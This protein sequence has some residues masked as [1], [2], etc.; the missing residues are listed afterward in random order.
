MIAETLATAASTEYL[1]S[2]GNNGAFGRFRAEEPI[3]LRRGERVVIR[4]TRGLE[5]GAVLCPVTANHTRFL[6]SDALP[7]LLVRRATLEDEQE[8]R[9]LHGVGQR[10]FD[11]GRRLAAE[12]EL[13]LE[14]LD[15]ELLLDGRRA[16]LQHVSNRQCDC[17]AFLAELE[18]RHGIQVWLENLA[19][20][21]AKDEDHGGCDKPDCGRNS[22]GCTSCSTG[23]CS[24]CG[25]GKVDMTAYFAHLRTQ[26][27][28]KRMPL[29]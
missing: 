18:R 28:Q 19:S 5:L 24:S 23:G 1:V 17:D 15:V 9:R 4:T 22:G 6:D 29:L 16:I 8:S 10:L 14:I 3:T 21:A 12:L 20:P 13:P 7:G 27:E 2:H 26:M 25:S 11:E